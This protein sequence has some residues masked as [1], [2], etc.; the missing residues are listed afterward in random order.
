MKKTAVAPS[1]IAFIKYWGKKDEKLRLPSH[2]NISMNLDGLLTTTTVQFGGALAKDEITVNGQQN[3]GE[4]RK[5]SA[6]LDRIREIAGIKTRA[7]VVSV[8]NFP[9]STGLSSSASGFAA[10]T[11]A[12]CAASGLS[13]TQKELSILA[14][15]GSGSACRSIPDGFVQWLEGQDSES[16]YAVTLFPAGHWDICDT[17]AVVSDEKKDVPTSAGHRLAPTSP[18]YETRLS[19]MDKKIKRCRELLR[20]KDFSAFGE[21]VE[22]EALEMHA[23]MI[24]S[25]PPLLYW[26][27]TTVILMKE[28]R[29]WRREENIEAYFTINTGQDVHIISRKKDEKKVTEKLKGLDC[30]KRI[31]PNNPSIGTRLTDIH[32]F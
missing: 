7:K 28:V 32:L 27:P 13:L 31:I 6:H 25:T 24:T 22:K 29:R 1:N 19:Q 16:S 21:L 23:I 14:R 26:L 11:V 9:S 10:L 5:V 4:V 18:F 20:D 30:V 2:S 3:D 17:V 12:A 15:L 8:N